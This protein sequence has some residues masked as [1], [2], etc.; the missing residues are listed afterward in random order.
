MLRARSRIGKYRIE[1]KL[2][3]GGFATVYHA[4]DTIEGVHVALK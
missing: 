4:W 2:A 1:K 3:Q